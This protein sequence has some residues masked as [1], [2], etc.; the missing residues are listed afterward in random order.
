MMDLSFLGPRVCVIGPSSSGKSTLAVALGKRLGLPVVHLDQWA[1]EP[2]TNWNRRPDDVWVKDHDALIQEPAWILEGNYSV[3]MP[4]RFRRATAVLWTDLPVTGCLIR[5]LKRS[6]RRSP[7]VRPGNLE[8]ASREV[9]L[10]LIRYL[11]V[12]YPH[13]RLRYERLLA[14]AA[15]PDLH[16]LRLHSW[17]ALMT[18]QRQQRLIG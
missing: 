18:W 17:E 6:F 1:H 12:Q 7:Q 16:V 5:Y 3:C 2:G 10:S 15:R 9:S 4:Q 13:N 14:E 11:L 8:G